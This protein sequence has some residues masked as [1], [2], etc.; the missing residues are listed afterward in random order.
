MQ[1][2]YITQMFCRKC[3]AIPRN[4][5]LACPECGIRCRNGPRRKARSR[6][7]KIGYYSDPKNIPKYI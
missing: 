5:E 7:L 1:V 4:N 3:G 6:K 2:N